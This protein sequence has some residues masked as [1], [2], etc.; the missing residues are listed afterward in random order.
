M[1]LRISK[2]FYKDF[3]VFFFILFTAFFIT[4]NSLNAEGV[5]PLSE[6]AP[7]SNEN[8]LVQKMPEDQQGLKVY[9]DPDTGELISQPEEEAA[10]A[11]PNNS[12]FGE[13]DGV[14]E[15]PEEIIHPDGSAT[16]IMPE[17]M[18]HSTT[19]TIDENGNQTTE[20]NRKYEHTHE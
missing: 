7:Q 13:G 14:V 4:L 12:V 10:V 8:G 6:K 16:V 5:D 18:Q 3:M 1:L 20:C 17:S 15:Q 9:I 2:V 11:Q 19:I